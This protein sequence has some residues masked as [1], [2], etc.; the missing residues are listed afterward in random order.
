MGCYLPVEKHLLLIQQGRGEA[1]R[2]QV[3]AEILNLT[4]GRLSLAPFDDVI[5]VQAVRFL[6]Q[7][8]VR[9]TRK[10]LL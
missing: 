4:S 8:V 6:L 10:H 7:Y 3:E 5:A 2:G 1:S 9:Q